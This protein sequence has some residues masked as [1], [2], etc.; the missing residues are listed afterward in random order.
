MLEGVQMAQETSSLLLARHDGRGWPTP[1]KQ[2]PVRNRVYA[3][4]CSARVSQCREMRCLNAGRCD[5]K[6]VRLGSF[7]QL[8]GAYILKAVDLRHTTQAANLLSV[9]MLSI[10][11]STRVRRCDVEGGSA[12]LVEGGPK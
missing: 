10:R 1:T 6:R 5:E 11:S 9:E 12:V 3:I 7:S 8:A 2:T 4:R